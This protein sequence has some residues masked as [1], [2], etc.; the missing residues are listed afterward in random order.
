MTSCVGYFR[1]VKASTPYLPRHLYRRFL[2]LSNDEDGED[3]EEGRAAVDEQPERRAR[4]DGADDGEG[5]RVDGEGGRVDGEGGRVDGEG[6]RDAPPPPARFPP[7]EQL[8]RVPSMDDLPR[9]EH[10][11]VDESRLARALGVPPNS[12]AALCDR[13]LELVCE[14]CLR[15]SRTLALFLRGV[16]ATLDVGAACV[17]AAPRRPAPSRRQRRSRPRGSSSA[18]APPSVACASPALRVDASSPLQSSSL[19][20][21]SV[22]FFP[23]LPTPKRV[24]T[25]VPPRP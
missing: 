12:R 3:G 1:V 20:S 6:G 9:L 8:P 25:Y 18:A 15:P 2:E 5:G 13:L 17:C 21:A 16:V 14:H 10:E 22:S 11:M 4:A 19:E 7:P 23:S 24:R